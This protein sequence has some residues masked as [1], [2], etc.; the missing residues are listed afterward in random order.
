MA[1][2]LVILFIF[3]EQTGKKQ[4]NFLQINAQIFIEQGVYL[5]FMESERK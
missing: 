3:H 5:M 2:H 4:T 1:S